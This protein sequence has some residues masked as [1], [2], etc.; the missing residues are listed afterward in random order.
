MSPGYLAALGSG[1]G[2]TRSQATGVVFED[3]TDVAGL[4]GA[5]GRLARTSPP[6]GPR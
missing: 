3:V 6:R 5:V 4:R 2:S 1:L